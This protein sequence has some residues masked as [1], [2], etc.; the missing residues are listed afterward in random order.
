MERGCGERVWRES[1]ESEGMERGYG[2]RVWREHG[3]EGMERGYGERVH[4]TKNLK[5]TCI[6][7]ILA[8]GSGL[9]GFTQW[10][11]VA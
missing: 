4:T 9:Y 3:R 6:A 10:S 11:L 7:K 1:M 2:E 8:S 5:H